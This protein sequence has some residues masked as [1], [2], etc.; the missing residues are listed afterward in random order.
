MIESNFAPGNYGH[1]SYSLNIVFFFFFCLLD[2]EER[3]IIS[4]RII[5]LVISIFILIFI[6]I[7]LLL[8][9]LY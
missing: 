7:L 9:S 5:H 4:Y 8:K 2:S 6:L 1:R 3:L